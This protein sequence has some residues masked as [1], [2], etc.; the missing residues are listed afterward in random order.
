MINVTLE[1]IANSINVLKTL[2]QQTLNA[3]LSYKLGKIIIEVENEYNALQRTR[4]EIIGKYSQKD[5]DGKIIQNDGQIT[6]LPEYVE[7]AQKELT[8]LL[9]TE[10][11]LN[12]LPLK[13][14]ELESYTFSPADMIV[15]MPFIEE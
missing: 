9:E 11:S 5:E 13:I 1:Q 7:Q 8:E 12:A 15:L 14:D 10:T 4:M 6:I 3:R 2:S